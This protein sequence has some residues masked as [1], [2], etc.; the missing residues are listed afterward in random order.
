[1]DIIRSLANNSNKNKLFELS[2]KLTNETI[3]IVTKSD[4]RKQLFINLSENGND[5]MIL[6]DSNDYIYPYFNF[7]NQ[8]RLLIIINGYSRSG[9][10]IFLSNYI[11]K[12]YIRQI[13]HVK[14]F[15][16][17]PTNPNLDASLK[18]YTNL[19]YIDASKFELNDN[20]KTIYI[21]S[22]SLVIIDDIDSIKNNDIWRLLSLLVNIGGKF[23]INVTFITHAN[24]V[25]IPSLKLN[26][27][28]DC[29][30]YITYNIDN[31]RFYTHYNKDAPIDD[32]KRDV[33]VTCRPKFKILISDKRVLKY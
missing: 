31:N 10:S 21:F 13:E 27:I 1:M 23:H 3:A 7:M 22:N 28:T 20:Q 16:I 6:E 26:L 24:T 30:Y 17:C 8:D 9:K 19:K 5:R 14:I 15:Y 32:F 2:K 25:I 11:I 12:N 29:D 18:Q 33:I 4:N